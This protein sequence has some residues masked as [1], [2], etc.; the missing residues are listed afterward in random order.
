M[1]VTCVWQWSLVCDLSYVKPMMT[2]LQM[3][4]V[5]VGA[6]LGGQMSDSLGRRLTVYATSLTHT[7]C[8]VVAAFSVSWQMFAVM[9]T[10]TGVTLGVYL[11][12]SFS[13]PLEFVS[14][15]WRQVRPDLVLLLHLDQGP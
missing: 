13:F 9:R 4:G 3:A 12:A 7:V 14:P 15:A 10:L 6:L 1:S 8:C 11:V 2:S 5:L